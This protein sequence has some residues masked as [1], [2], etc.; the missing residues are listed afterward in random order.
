VESLKR[1]DGPMNLARVYNAEGRLDD[2]VAALQRAD[3]YSDEAGYPRWTWAWL[4]GDINR[5][6]GH[7][8]AAIQN[9]R[10]VLED[11]TP[12]MQARGFDFSL[13]YE[14]I[15]LLGQTLFD[16]GRLRA[17]Q[18]RTDEARGAWQEAVAAFHKTLALDSENVTAHHNLQLLYAELGDEEKSGEHERLHL[19]YKADDNAQGR[20]ERLARERYPAAN[21]AAEAVV[22]YPLQRTGAPK[23]ASD[24]EVGSMTESQSAGSGDPRTTADFAG[25]GQ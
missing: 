2:A 16:L 20:A 4:S 15:N 11:R 10:S 1:W 19:K 7:L 13:D 14:V 17:R 6:Q 23:L 21:H 22:K 3:S 24:F 25:G 5:Q 8:T 18:G 12:D 9:L